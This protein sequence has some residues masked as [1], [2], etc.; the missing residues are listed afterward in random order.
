MRASTGE[1]HVFSNFGRQS[2]SVQE[3]GFSRMVRRTTF[4]LLVL[5]SA[6]G[7]SFGRYSMN[8]N[9]E[10]LIPFPELNVLPAQW[11]PD[12]AE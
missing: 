5:V 7:C 8:M 2:I 10:K 12:S 4:L 1:F 11:E 3:Q 9:R 6:G